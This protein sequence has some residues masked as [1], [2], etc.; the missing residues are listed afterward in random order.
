MKSTEKFSSA[1]LD[2]LIGKPYTYS[3]LRGGNKF[4]ISSII[5]G[6]FFG[7]SN[8]TNLIDTKKTYASSSSIAY[9]T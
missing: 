5:E 1:P 7:F 8:D 4:Q 9:V 6:G 2:P 3:V